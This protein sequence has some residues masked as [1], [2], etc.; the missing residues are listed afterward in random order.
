MILPKPSRRIVCRW[1]ADFNTCDTHI[2]LFYS[3]LFYTGST[4]SS[5]MPTSIL[6]SLTPPEHSSGPSTGPVYIHTH[7]TIKG[8]WIVIVPLPHRFTNNS[9][10][11]TYHA[12]VKWKDPKRTMGEVVELASHCL[13]P[14]ISTVHL[15]W[16][17]IP[18]MRRCDENIGGSH[19]E[20]ITDHRLIH[21]DAPYANPI[22]RQPPT[23]PPF[24]WINRFGTDMMDSDDLLE[25]AG[26]RV[27]DLG[28]LS[29]A[30]PGE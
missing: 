17:A 25:G 2:S 19:R 9:A 30:I 12:N 24:D 1:Y 7:V 15:C 4:L 8:V 14:E 3:F 22:E 16:H 5:L 6:L 23:V 11:K 10:G 13:I 27:S 20:Q 28:E 21:A 18:S 29:A 26:C